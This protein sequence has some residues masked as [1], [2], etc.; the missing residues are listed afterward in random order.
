MS[1]L[2]EIY[3]RFTWIYYMRSFQTGKYFG[4][5]KLS[6]KPSRFDPVRLVVQH[7]Y[8]HFDFSIHYTYL[9][10]H[11]FYSIMFC[12]DGMKIASINSHV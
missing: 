10:I 11:C 5:R 8:T 12:V 1:H 3:E 4:R 9:V 2:D 6:T 7:S